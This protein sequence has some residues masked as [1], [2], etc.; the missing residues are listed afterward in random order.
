MREQGMISS[1]VPPALSPPASPSAALAA[2]ATC[3]VRWRVP[4]TSAEVVL[5]HSQ[6]TGERSVRVDGVLVISYAPL[7]ARGSNDPHAPARLHANGHASSLCLPLDLLRS[8]QSAGE[9]LDE[10]AV[11]GHTYLLQIWR[12]E[13]HDAASFVV[14]G[15]GYSLQVGALGVFAPT[16]TVAVTPLRDGRTA[17]WRARAAEASRRARA[18][19]GSGEHEAS[20]ANRCPSSSR[21]AGTPAAAGVA[22]AA[23]AACMLTSGGASLA[24]A[25]A[26]AE[27]GLEVDAGVSA[28][29]VV[30]PTPA[31]TGAI[32]P[33]AE[34]ASSSGQ[35]DSSW[36]SVAALAEAA[37]GG[38][39]AVAGSQLV[40]A[41]ARA[42]VGTEGGGAT[43][44][45]VAPA[46]EPAA[47]VA[48][49]V[50]AVA[51]EDVA[52]DTH[53]PSAAPSAAAE[54]RAAVAAASMDVDA[55]AY[56]PPAAANLREGVEERSTAGSAADGA[57][58]SAVDD[59]AIDIVASSAADTSSPPRVA[60]PILAQAGRKLLLRSR[61]VAVLRAAVAEGKCAEASTSAAA[62][63]ERG[64]AAATV[65]SDS[66]DPWAM[67][68]AEWAQLIEHEPQI[69]LTVAASDPPAVG[70]TADAAWHAPPPPPEATRLRQALKLERQRVL[71]AM[72]RAGLHV[73]RCSS[74]TADGAL[75]VWFTCVTATEGRLMVE[76]HR[77]GMEKRLLPEAMPPAIHL[78]RSSRLRGLAR[79]LRT[80]C[81]AFLL[82]CSH[83]PHPKDVSKAEAREASRRVRRTNC[84]VA[85][86]GAMA[87]AAEATAVARGGGRSRQNSRLSGRLSGGGGGAGSGGGS[88]G[89]GALA[90]GAISD[91]D[92]RRVAYSDFDL[93][94]WRLFRPFRA[95]EIFFTP[96]ERQRLVASI[97]SSRPA[98]GG[99]GIDMPML[100]AGK[101][102]RVP[103]P[104][105]EEAAELAVEAKHFG[106]AAPKPMADLNELAGAAAAAMPATA[107]LATAAG[108]GAPPPASAAFDAMFCTHSSRARAVLA[109][110][111]STRR[112]SILSR[113][114]LDELRDYFGEK[115]A[116]YFGFMHHYTVWLSLLALPA[117][118][119]LLLLLL[120]VS[121]ACPDAHARYARDVAAADAYASARE[122]SATANTSAAVLA[123]ASRAGQPMDA[124]YD[125]LNGLYASGG[126]V[127]SLNLSSSGAAPFLAADPPPTLCAWSGAD[128]LMTP[129]WVVGIGVWVVYFLKHWRRYEAT[130]TFRWNVDDFACE[131]PI[132]PEFHRHPATRHDKKG[133]YIRQAG[134]LP[135]GESFAPYFP[136]A[137]R[138]SRVMRAAAATFALMALSAVG[139]LALFALRLSVASARSLSIHVELAGFPV[140]RSTFAS[141]ITSVLNTLF[142]TAF[143]GVY[144]VVGVRLVAWQNH[145]YASEYEDSLIELN[146]A[147]QF[148]NSY[149][150]FFYIAFAKPCAVHARPRPSS[151]FAD[152]H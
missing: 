120:P 98:E 87:R 5:V 65:G 149:I 124:T 16:P 130:L 60:P 74:A 37:I 84:G 69:V 56:A 119:S 59:V 134:F 152:L 93:A 115:A 9:E 78:D 118:L 52:R 80:A 64:E 85:V 116:F 76:A 147:F 29:A 27:A 125:L 91:R 117:L 49:D 137:Q 48:P 128:T 2:L 77:L 101:A 83:P 23:G 55:D 14:G 151:L 94:R 61:T 106:W 140:T 139:T 132:R 11:D 31:E 150:S 122:Q 36:P 50:A 82:R 114:P 45:A 57:A 97:L 30:G 8:A 47:A 141:L 81:D 25:A 131:E 113:P 19:R 22:G 18:G 142:I 133:V 68:P 28:S 70:D 143:N 73:R 79:T 110:R 104:P 126:G 7:P 41:A 72:R 108:A 10:F 135:L 148:I 17:N 63:G 62:D 39:V 13:R 75:C 43:A 105:M 20:P 67:V 100:L 12:A 96:M 86:G 88:S 144:R 15:F 4:G 71:A 112:P 90:D 33:R 66:G 89:G 127:G 54:A 40:A 46:P 6:R 42:V 44:P 99:A 138:R 32:A 123:A 34:E 107:I 1:S 26:C 146:F 109:A 92:F 145:R 51:N 53:A 58:G 35:A 38:V 121:A 136:R 103:L 102:W 111:V 24:A 3:H 129:L 95:G 21:A